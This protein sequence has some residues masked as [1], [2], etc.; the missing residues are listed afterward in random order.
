MMIVVETDFEERAVSSVEHL[1]V[2]L[3]SGHSDITL[4]A[5]I[6]VGYYIR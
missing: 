5:T 6:R 3:A 1:I 2:F 4:K